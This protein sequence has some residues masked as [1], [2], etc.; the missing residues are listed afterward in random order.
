VDRHAR[1]VLS[2]IH[3]L[4]MGDREMKEPMVYILAS[5]KNGTLYINVTSNIRQ[6]I[7]Q[8]QNDVMEGF[9]KEY[10]IHILVYYESHASMASAI[11]REKQ[12][13]K[14]NRAWKIKLIEAANPEWCDLSAQS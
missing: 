11:M 13:K 4:L 12:L 7:W 9:T 6:R 10:R 8:H 3:F 5:R 1:V 14:W 2:G